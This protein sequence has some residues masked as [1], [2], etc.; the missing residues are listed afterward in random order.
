MEHL[1][2][3]RADAADHHAAE[4]AVDLPAGGIGAEQARIAFRRLEV[5]TA[6][7]EPGKAQHLAFDMATDAFHGARYDGQAR[8]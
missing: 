4:V 3:Q 2:K 6:D 8:A 1:Q 5:D 7:G